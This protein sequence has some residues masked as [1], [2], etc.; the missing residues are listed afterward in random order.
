[1]RGMEDSGAPRL[2]GRNTVIDGSQKHEEIITVG[3]IAS[4]RLVR[5]LFGNE[6]G[7]RHPYLL[8]HQIVAGGRIHA[9]R[10]PRLFRADTRRIERDQKL[11]Q[12]R[13]LFRRGGKH[14]RP[15]Q[16][17]QA[18]NEALA[19]IDHPDIA[20]YPRR[21]FWQAAMGR[22]ADARLRLRIVQERRLPVIGGQHFCRKH[23]RPLAAP[24]G[25]V[26]AV[27]HGKDEGGGWIAL[28]NGGDDGM[29][30]FHALP[31]TAVLFSRHETKQT[32]FEKRLEIA[33]GEFAAFVMVRRSQAENFGERGCDGDG[34]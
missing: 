14:D 15:F 32:R 34:V 19:A 17:R 13:R 16:P 33:G 8:K 30:G 2:A 10:F 18:G 4:Q 25:G 1:M 9:G 31:P 29:R 24:D 22:R 26:D 7:K 27:M 23:C 20:L 5:R 6:I 11:D 12:A 28:G 21:R 3:F